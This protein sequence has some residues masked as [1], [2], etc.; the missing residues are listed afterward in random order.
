MPRARRACRPRRSARSD[1]HLISDQPVTP[2][3]AFAGQGGECCPGQRESRT[4]SRVLPRHGGGHRGGDR[5]SV[6]AFV[7]RGDAAMRICMIASSRFP[8]REP[9]AGGLE[10]HTFSLAREL[11]RRGHELVCL[12]SARVTARCSRHRARGG[13]LSLERGIPRRR[14]RPSGAWMQEHHAYLTL[15]MRLAQR[16]GE[17]LRPRPQ[18]QPPPPASGHGADGAHPRRDDPAHAAGP[19]AG[20]GDRRGGRGGH[21]RGGQRRD[22]PRLGPRRLDGHH[23][24]RR[25]PRALDARA[26]EVPTPSG[27][28]ASPRRRRRTRPS[29][30]R[31]AAAAPSPSPG[32]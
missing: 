27:A 7:V 15:M 16:G 26:R 13:R 4:A 10:A 6:C 1:R 14:R 32:P 22:E 19:L 11:D 30:R 12:R 21:V 2:L 9:F 29:T 24:E 31:V 17:D 28:V 5:P 23:P 8:I 25:R 3:T 18:Q 20:V